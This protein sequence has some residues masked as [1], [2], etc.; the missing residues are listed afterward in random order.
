MSHG[1]R[2]YSFFQNRQCE[3]FPCHKG[4]DTEKFNCLLYYFPLYMLGKDCGGRFIYNERG[5]KVCTDCIYPHIKENY[6]GVLSR[7]GDIR[8]MMLKNDRDATG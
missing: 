3:Y 7:Y 6:D 4:V 1:D 2:R 5:D 8:A